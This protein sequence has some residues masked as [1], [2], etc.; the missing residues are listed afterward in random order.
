MDEALKESSSDRALQ[1]LRGRWCFNVSEL[2]WVERKL[3]SAIYGE[4]PKSSYKEALDSFLQ[5]RVA[6]L[7]EV[8]GSHA[9]CF[10][11]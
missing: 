1:H 10:V 2:S 3:A 4:I 5:V 8:R 6:L 7:G 9:S 11:G